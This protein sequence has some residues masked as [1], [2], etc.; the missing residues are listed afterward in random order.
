VVSDLDV[1]DALSDTFYYSSTLV[2]E[3]NGEGALGIVS[4]ELQATKERVYQR[5]G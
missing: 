5:V 1:G 2:S 4:R 3:H